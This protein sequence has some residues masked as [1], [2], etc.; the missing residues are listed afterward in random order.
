MSYN[1]FSFWYRNDTRLTIEHV[2]SVYG[3]TASGNFKRKPDTIER[4]TVSGEFYEN[5]IRS[6]TFFNGFCGGTCRAYKAYTAAGYIPVKVVTVNPGKTEKHVD[7]FNFI[8]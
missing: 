2:K 3:I 5:F 6:V 7:I 8:F 4:E 1:N